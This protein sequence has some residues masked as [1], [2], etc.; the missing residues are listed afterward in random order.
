MGFFGI[1]YPDIFIPE[2]G[3]SRIYDSLFT[4]NGKKIEENTHLLLKKLHRVLKVIILS[5]LV[6]C[7]Q[8]NFTI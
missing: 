8:V 6:L 3:M 7:T 4:Y 2:I 5:C 1:K